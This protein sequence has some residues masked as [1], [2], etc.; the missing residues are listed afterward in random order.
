MLQA[1]SPD[2]ASHARVATIAVTQV[3]LQSS[4]SH[5]WT[6]S[7][8]LVLKDGSKQRITGQAASDADAVACAVSD[9][10][11]LPIQIAN[12]DAQLLED[13]QTRCV[14]GVTGEGKLPLRAAVGRYTSARRE[15]ALAIAI[16]RGAGHA[17]LLKPAYQANS[18]KMLRRW[19]R[20]LMD[21]I[22]QCLPSGEWT[23]WKRLEA[24]GILLEHLNRVASAAVVTAVN[25]P[26]PETVLSL[27]DNSA[28]LFD[29]QGRRRDSYLDTNLWLAWYPGVRNGSMTVEEVM[30]TMPAAPETAIPWIVRL[31]ENPTSWLRFR[32][33]VDLAD[34]DVLH[35]LLGRGLQD[36]D[37]AFVL[38]F[39][40]G[41]AKRTTWL[42][43][44]L[45]K[46][47]LT[48]LYPEPYRIPKF[49]LPAFDLGVQCGN[50]TGC[51]GL[52][53]QPL[54]DWIGLTLDEA[55]ARAQI[56]MS[57]VLRYYQQ[58]QQQIPF[59]I[60]SLRLP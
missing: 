5:T 12:V 18:Q 10:C 17:G 50:S 40:M 41:T 16:L 24:E 42:E 44:Y 57:I 4:A 11:R 30:E 23:S 31:F 51:A 49:L 47:I 37:E 54:K 55:R 6:C 29:S 8:D 19:S 21:E 32:G 45:F 7:L 52:Y 36:Q 27:F 14:V 59:T 3:T 33:A 58:E 1:H 26:E 9:L 60:A 2:S 35:V 39:A 25:H 56:D 46:A 13:G 53:K 38:G 28:W 48:R 34:H 22:T 20:E 15:F 43:S